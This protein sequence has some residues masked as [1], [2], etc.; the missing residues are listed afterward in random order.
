M[1]RKYLLACLL[2]CTMLTGCISFTIAE[3]ISITPMDTD[4]LF[5][6]RDTDFSWE[7]RDM[8]EIQLQNESVTITE[9]GVY[10]LSGSIENGQIIV[11]VPKDDKVQLVLADVSVHCDTHAALYVKQ[12]DKVFIT[13]AP[14]T[15]NSLSC[16]ETFVQ[17]DENNVDAA[18][19]SRD[20]ITLN[21][22]GC[23]SIRSP[24]GHG[25]VSKD[26]LTV[27]GGSY[28]IHAAA[29]GFS[30]QD[31]ICISGGAF[32]VAAGKDGFHAEHDEDS[33]LGFVFLSGGAFDVTA[34]Q[35]GIS[36][37]GAMEITGGTFTLLCGGGSENGETHQTGMMN[38]P[39]GGRG[40]FGGRPDGQGSFSPWD[41]NGQAAEDNAASVSKKGLKAGST[42]LLSGGT[43]SID[44]ADDALHSNQSML[45][46][47]GTFTI[48]TGDDGV[49]AEDTLQIN[50]GHMLIEKS[51]EGL[52][53]L[54]IRLNGGDI[55][56]IADDDGL[57]A[58][59]GTDESGYGN[60]DA[61]SDW[62][63]RGRGGMHAGN[64]S[65]II[66]DGILSIT[67][68]G[69]GIDANGSFRMDGGYVTVC[70]PTRGDTATLDYDTTAEI[71]GG[72]FIG[73]GAM[74]MAQTF[75]GG[76]QGKLAVQVGNAKA[77]STIT[78]THE[79]GREIL[80][81]CA[82]M[83]YNLVILSSPDIIQGESYTI[84]IGTASGTFAAQ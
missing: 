66:S 72:T 27:T 24:G 22:E 29:H 1:K 71:N 23:L 13:L 79:N 25:V 36:A 2:L 70:G 11:D 32:H 60:M 61:F 49:H 40:P 65:I 21:G 34:Q 76:T 48:R 53:A 7:D 17:T 4:T 78:L 33:S 52:E 68:S 38:G 18:L 84:Q 58:A 50:G 3:E 69:D 28:I 56:L 6:V 39:R 81:Y 31:N 16:G 12:A 35:D 41:N 45:L 77:G 19:F 51:Y 59:G 46:T 8:T 73:T 37:S 55:T 75:S 83:D 63:G 74:G 20:D 44:S 64:G 5:S 9:K 62:G 10:L 54:H 42:L 82:P 15:E 47:S 14:D 30:A 43:Y 80:S 67:A 57:N 26:E